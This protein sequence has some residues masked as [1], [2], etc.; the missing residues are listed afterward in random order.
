MIRIEPN[1]M[2]KMPLKLSLFIAFCICTQ[3]AVAQQSRGE[4]AGEGKKVREEP[5]FLVVEDMPE[6]PGGDKA[7]FKYIA[8]NINYPKE[9]LKHKIEGR[10]T[11]QFVIDEEGNV[12]DAKVLKGIGYGCDEEALRVVNSMPKW[13]PGKQRGDNVRV[14][15]VLPI[16]F[17]LN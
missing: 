9:A 10:V 1:R 14:R 15:F 16:R 4:Q 5:E 17:V 12:V 11:I 7:M 8:D 3:F 6:F 2:I 13:K